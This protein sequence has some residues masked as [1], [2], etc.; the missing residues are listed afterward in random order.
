MHKW[1]VNIKRTEPQTSRELFNVNINSTAKTTLDI[2]KLVNTSVKFA[3]AI[4]WEALNTVSKL[5]VSKD[6]KLRFSWVAG[7]RH[8][9]LFGNH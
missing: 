2:E 7:S 4:S 6:S 9:K 8:E 5:L 1:G 3:S